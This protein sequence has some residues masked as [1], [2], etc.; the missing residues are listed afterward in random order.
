MK[1]KLTAILLS[2]VMVVGLTACGGEESGTTVTT[3]VSEVPMANPDVVYLPE[4]LDTDFDGNSF[5]DAT[6]MIGSKLYMF[7]TLYDNNTVSYEMVVYDTEDGNLGRTVL[8]RPEGASVNAYVFPVSINEDGSVDTM[9]TVD[10]YDDECNL[11]SSQSQYCVNDLQGKLI[12]AEDV[13]ES[14]DTDTYG[15]VTNVLKTPEG[16]YIVCSWDGDNG[17]KKARVYSADWQL[18]GD[19][20]TGNIRNVDNFLQMSDGSILAT[21]RNENGICVAPVD[22]SAR[23]LGAVTEIKS[24]ETSGKLWSGRENRIFYI[25]GT[26]LYSTDIKTCETFM[27]MDILAMD[28]NAD[29][30]DN[31]FELEDGRY[32]FLYWNFSSN[33][34]MQIVLATPVDSESVPERE[35][36]TVAGLYASQSLIDMAVEFNK[37]STEYRIEVVSYADE[38]GDYHTALVNMQNDIAAGNI[39]DIVGVSSDLPWQN[40]AE[41]GIFIDLYPLMEADGEF[42]KEDFLDNVMTAME[43]DGA[44]YVLPIE[45]G[46]R[47]FMANS[48]SVQG[49]ENLHPQNLL[50]LE[51]TLPEGSRLLGYEDQYTLMQLMVYYNL[52]YYVDY[53]TG[54]CNFDSEEFTTM[55]EWIKTKPMEEDSSGESIPEGLR[56]GNILLYDAYFS[57]ISDFQFQS[58]VLGGDVTCMGINGEESNFIHMGNNAFAVSEG[59]EHK[60]AAWQFIKMFLTEEFQTGEQLWNIPVTQTGFEH[61][62]FQAQQK[63]IID[64]YFWGG[65][66][67]QIGAATEE[68]AECFRNIVANATTTQSCDTMIQM[69]IEEETAPF[70]E[71][72]KS[73]E[74]VAAIIQNRV[75]LYLKEKE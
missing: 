49:V 44:L 70:F 30:I 64:K 62:L 51:S 29:Y 16:N 66:E 20:D 52:D 56:N 23:V 19:M 59:C 10:E 31:V 41:K 67:L 42:A 15:G 69:I 28:L 21:G 48:Q 75:E 7:H 22:A 6:R 58:R 53:A 13:T 65:M 5:F 32:I 4:F 38:A 50:Q 3:G 39:P 63:T 35:T 73:A 37:T 8:E 43:V 1:R 17:T 12:L 24:T 18:L 40:W 74:E 68:E 71:G 60:D 2:V 55:L 61:M 25:N 36:L 11:I 34:G 26:G 46:V 27:I 33:E 9:Q 45:F 47:T 72:Q 54:E 57:S 14:L